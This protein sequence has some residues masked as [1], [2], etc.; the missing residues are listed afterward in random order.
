MPDR[1]FTE[2]DERRLLEQGIPVQEAL[3]Q[4]ELFARPPQFVRLER[5]CT[6]GDGIE[7]IPEDAFPGLLESHARAS[8]AGRF[9][10]CVPASGAATRM[11]KN[12]L[13]FQR[14]PGRELAWSTILEQAE[15]GQGEATA[16]VEFM[17]EMDRFPFRD[18]LRKGLFRRGEDLEGLARVGAFQPI[19]DALLDSLGMD[20]DQRPKGLIP[21]HAYA[22]GS[23]TAFEEHLVEAAAYTSDADGL[24]RLHFTVSPE[25]MAG[26]EQLFS[27]SGKSLAERLGVRCEIG[28]SVQK[29]ETDTLAADDD[30]RPLHDSEGRLRLRPGGHG[31]LIENLNDLGADLI[32]VKNIDNVQPD[33]GRAATVQ[34]KKL[35]A[36]YLVQLQGEAFDHLDRLSAP[37]P[38]GEII[39]AAEKFVA[40]RLSIDLDGRGE[41]SS[42]QARRASLIA[43][44][45]R[46]LRVCGVV[47][48]TGE[49]GGGP[50]WVRRSDGTPSRQIVETAQ[51][52][53]GD[54]GQLELLRSSTHFNPVDLVCAVRDAEGKPYDL[55]RFIDHDAVIITRKSVDG[56]AL[57]ALERPGLW[58]G[59]MAGWNT[60]FVEVPLET[61]TPVKTVLDLLR[62][63][64][65]A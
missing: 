50:F 36:G 43:V 30:G 46:P 20:L 22:E 14:G 33:C 55:R 63:E 37:A 39:A 1:P 52:D 26:F 42:Y 64:H 8:R 25:H 57:R 38:S 16:L 21:F 61:F 49:P 5:A 28:F 15:E 4:L 56:R 53:S 60:V 51:V 29:P 7:R 27:R 40:R 3:R 48:N 58:N 31:S 12:L 54:A 34:W 9:T 2:D 62:P 18:E 45:N 65:Q 23:R 11:F 19:L 59:S 41:P 44:L 17:R 35:L 47:P 13:H 6:V 10:R 24:C 32:F